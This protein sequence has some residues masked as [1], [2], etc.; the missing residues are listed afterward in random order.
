MPFV[1]PKNFPPI[2][3]AGLQAKS[4]N[5]KAAIKY[6][7][8][9]AHAV[10]C[11]KS[12]PTREEEENVARQCVKAYPFLEASSGTGHVSIDSVHVIQNVSTCTLKLQLAKVFH[13]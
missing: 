1:I 2:V 12:Y 8:E 3:A 9:I 13:A 4:L 6:I 10:F 5:G 7:S 11:F